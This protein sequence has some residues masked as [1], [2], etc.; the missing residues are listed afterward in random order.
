MTQWRDR[1]PPF[2]TVAPT[3][4][5]HPVLIGHAAS[6]PRIHDCLAER[7]GALRL[8]ALRALCPPPSGVDPGAPPPFLPPY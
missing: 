5:P 6:N 4:V 7:G 1:S 8:E 3:L 2:P